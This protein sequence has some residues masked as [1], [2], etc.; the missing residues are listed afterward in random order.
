MFRLM[1]CLCLQGKSVS[2]RW[3]RYDWGTFL[4]NHFSIHQNNSVILK[5]EA[6][7]HSAITVRTVPQYDA[8]QNSGCDNVGTEQ[9][10]FVW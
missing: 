6:D 4:S 8:L 2:R 7:H 10:G 9:D 3:V 1:Y 5:M